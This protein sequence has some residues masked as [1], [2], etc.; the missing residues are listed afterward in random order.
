MGT[1]EESLF[2]EMGVRDQ[3]GLLDADSIPNANQ[4]LTCFSCDEPMT[5]L[6]CYACGNKNDN[7]R[8]SVW[9]LGVELFQSLTA[10][11]G[12]I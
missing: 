1:E 4:S 12:L 5:G 10:F 11:V 3:S 8:R 7:Y 6:F 9:S 2:H